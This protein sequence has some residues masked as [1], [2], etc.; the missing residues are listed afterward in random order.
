VTEAP[1][2]DRITF[3][4]FR[5]EWLGDVESGN[6][7]S[8]KLGHRFANKLLTQWLDIDGS[9]DDLVYCDGAGDGGVDV[10]YLY[11]SGDSDADDDTASEGD[12]W[13]L[14]QSKYG[15]AF[16]GTRT[17]LE[18]SQKV[19]DALEGKRKLSSLAEGLFERLNN[20]RQQAS[21]RDR[22]VLV[23]GSETALTESQSRALQDVRSMG[24]ARLGSLFD[25]ES[26]SVET[27]YLRGLEE[28][29]PDTRLAIPLRGALASSGEG[30]LVGTIPLLEL[31]TFLKAYRAETE[32]LDQLYEKNVRRFLGARGKVNK[33]MQSTLEQ[34]PERFGLYNNGI[35]LVVHDFQTV[36]NGGVALADPFIVNGCQTTRTIW[37]VFHRRLEAGGTGASPELE[38]WIERA[39][40]GAVVVKIVKI[41]TAGEDLLQ[42]ITR[43]TNSQ[44]VVR[45]KDFL[46]LTSDFKSWASQMAEQYDIYLEIQRGGW[47][48]QR[49]LQR[50]RPE[51]RQF[52]EAANAFDLLK[53]YGAGWLGEAGTSY[54]RNQPFVPNGSIFKRIVDGEGD[55]EP[56]GAEDLYA[57]YLLQKASNYY[58]FGRGAPRPS[59]RQTRF[60]FYM[61]ALDVLRDVL[62]RMESREP[63]LKE[64]SKALNVLL[65]PENEA[66]KDSLLDTAIEVIDEYL[67][68]GTEDCVFGE[69]AF[70]NAFNNDL[71]GYLKWEQLGKERSSPHF[72]VLLSVTKHSMGHGR[73]TS[74]RR[75]IERAL[76]KRPETD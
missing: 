15:S 23:F 74:P 13:Y 43:Y 6:P 1:V 33:A 16:Q 75:I 53:V 64:L 66:A 56:F 18:E 3:E 49:A 2:E 30:L 59:R 62:I 38:E 28:T 35:T 20:F 44:N 45:E 67:T 61:V 50:Q 46:A 17:L 72:R 32:D 22:I 51:S 10:A 7:S 76:E 58:G 68:S 65:G 26:V 42:A 8:V 40:R 71:N 12:A 36:E 31:Y 52:E 57:A 24:R 63:S 25:V 21:E 27:I 54:G 4:D 70:Q 14:V 60:L 41:G 34:V 29:G 48:S 9:S 55:A 39:H 69:P 19:L 47:D 11:R 37:E 73:H 5:R